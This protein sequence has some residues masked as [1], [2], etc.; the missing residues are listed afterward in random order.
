MTS[1]VPSL[2]GKTSRKPGHRDLK[3][4]EGKPGE[5]SPVGVK[6]T[7]ESQ[8]RRYFFS[9]EARE[10]KSGFADEAPPLAASGFDVPGG[11]GKVEPDPVVVPVAPGQ[12]RGQL[13]LELLCQPCREAAC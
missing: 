2:S 12:P 4:T 5:H 9:Y 11:H 13:L 1:E 8:E 3:I 6:G 7:E 10:K